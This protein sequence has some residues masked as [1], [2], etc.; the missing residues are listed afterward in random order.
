MK[1]SA[2]LRHL[3][4]ETDRFL[5]CA[6]LVTSRGTLADRGGK[7]VL[8]MAQA[9]AADPRFDALSITD[10]P[11]G[12]P[13][14]TPDSLGAPLKEGGQEIII[15]LSCKDYNRNGLMGQA[16]KLA[17][18]G[19][20]NILT[21]SGDYPIAGYQG[22]AG[23]VFDIDSVGLLKLLDDMNQGRFQDASPGRKPRPLKRTGFFLGAVVNNHK[24]L[25]AEV[26]P[27]YFKLAKK[28]RTGA[29]FI[30][31]QIGYDARKQDELLKYMALHQLDVPVI[32]NVFVLS[33]G[34]ARFFHADRIP[35]VTVT[36]DLL[37]IAQTQA[38]SPD[39]GKA[40]FLELAAQQCAIAKGLGYRGAYLGGHVGADD[41]GKILELESQFSTDDWREFARQIRF[42]RP[43]EFFYFEADPD[44][45]LA[46]DQV[47]KTYLESK[48]PK[49]M[50][51]ARRQAPL[52][53]KINRRVHDRV[54]VPGKALFR[55][56]AAIS[57]KSEDG[58]LEKTLHTLE[59]ACKIPGFDCRDC[60]DCSLPDIAYLCPESQCVKNQRN[61]P[62]GGTRQGTCEIGEKDCIWA[63][64]YDRLK[65]YGEEET[66]LEGP[67]V[68]KDAGLKGTSAW[69]NTFLARDHHGKNTTDK[70]T[71]EKQE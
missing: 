69:G 43:G 57:R 6:E 44:T 65:G 34:V 10:N 25:E 29:R 19:F 17:N 23:G 15:H 50:R 28:I 27:Q 47:N 71:R 48:T 54:F 63:R 26:M 55:L 3:L 51:K 59:Q 20:D 4:E 68:I 14:I 8:D 39:K 36:D 22:Q 45:G 52:A 41:Y 58:R 16:W 18:D 40:F 13:M 30:I 64:A 1:K 62:C 70:N 5:T 24:R 32:A 2:T 31:S 35:G 38:K 9:L 12:N 67:V 11:G 53:Y 49:G 33:E 66:M 42:S 61:G 46:S 56:G 7:R 37:A 21:L 60:G